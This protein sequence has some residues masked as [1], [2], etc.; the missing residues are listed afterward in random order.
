MPLSNKYYKSLEESKLN[1]EMNNEIENLFEIHCDKQIL[2]KIISCA[3]KLKDEFFFNENNI[4]N[5]KNEGEELE[6]EKNNFNTKQDI[7][8]NK[9]VRELKKYKFFLDLEELENKNG[10]N[11][12]IINNVIEDYFI[13]YLGQK[14]D[15]D[16]LYL[17]KI[18][19]LILKLRFG[20]EKIKFLKKISRTI[21]YLQSNSEY[22][23]IMLEML[24]LIFKYNNNHYEL[25]E[26]IINDN[27]IHYEISE[28]NPQC[29]K[30]VNY[31]YY[32]IFES[33]IQSIFNEEFFSNIDKEKYF[34]FISA[35]KNLLQK[36]NIIEI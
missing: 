3:N 20:N 19:Y 12:E 21:I 36:A 7:I 9:I 22:I 8:M 1:K 32:M 28:I 33:M 2:K 23:Y 35:F 34:D 5:N 27:K 4:R 10:L 24:N 16:Y 26:K 25:M 13:L 29:K 31:S 14:F 18:L 17:Q 15:C 30:E 6:K 11:E